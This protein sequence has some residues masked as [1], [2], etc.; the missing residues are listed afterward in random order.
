MVPSVVR[1]GAWNAR[2]ICELPST[3]YRSGL[4]AMEGAEAT[5]LAIGRGDE[6]STI[7]L[8]NGAVTRRDPPRRC[9]RASRL[10]LPSRRWPFH[11]VR[12]RRGFLP[13]ARWHG[14]RLREQ[15][16]SSAER[17]ARLAVRYQSECDHRSDGDC[18]VFRERR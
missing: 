13:V 14:D 15:L 2:Y 1:M 6:I 16:D 18:G 8:R 3:R 10:R 4:A 7:S 9:V 5:K 11:A 12:I 17:A